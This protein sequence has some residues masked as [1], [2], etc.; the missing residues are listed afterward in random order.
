M[1]MQQVC[2]FSWSGW[3]TSELLLFNRVLLAGLL[4]FKDG[5]LALH[6]RPAQCAVGQIPNDHRQLADLTREKKKVYLA[7]LNGVWNYSLH[8]AF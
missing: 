4:S 6:F 7:V 8:T 2:G 5:V 3:R 1:H